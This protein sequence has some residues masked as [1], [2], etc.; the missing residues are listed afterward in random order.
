MAVWRMAD[1]QVHCPH[2]FQLASKSTKFAKIISEASSCRRLLHLNHEQVVIII[3]AAVNDDIWKDSDSLIV[4]GKGGSLR[5]SKAFHVEPVTIVFAVDVVARYLV[6]QI[7]G[8]AMW[9]APLV[10]VRIQEM[11]ITL[12]KLV[13]GAVQCYLDLYSAHNGHRTFFDG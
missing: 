5:E 9:H 12:N 7:D 13:N 11:L 2:V 10:G 4:F 3:T 6:F 1:D 8:K